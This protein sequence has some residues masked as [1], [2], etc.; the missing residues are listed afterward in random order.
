MLGN[1]GNDLVFKVTTQRIEVRHY[2]LFYLLQALF[3]AICC[4]AAVGLFK[5]GPVVHVT[6]LVFGLPIGLGTWAIYMLV[7]HSLAEGEVSTNVTIFRLNFVVSS[8]L[9][10][11]IL[12]EVLSV[13]KVIG[14]ALSSAAIVMLFFSTARP[15][16]RFRSG[17]RFSVPAC[18][19]AGA[20]N[21]LIKT[22]FNNG[23]LVVQLILYRYLL[24]FVLAAV[25]HLVGG[26]KLIERRRNLYSLSLL[27]GVAMMVALF[28]TFAAFRIGDVALVTPINQ[29]AFVFSTA[30]AV[31][32][33]KERL[34]IMKILALVLAV[35]SIITI[36]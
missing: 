28:F 26:G 33:L 32:I 19:L 17:I 23:A 13:R 9:A 34:S 11:L 6:S 25:L 4:M 10:V 36:A 24:V 18:L 7:L 20:L 35:A 31:L 27:S 5:L 2:S 3:I 12:G 1:T 21:I 16:R 30:G 29:L 14:L 8:I 15:G 22:A